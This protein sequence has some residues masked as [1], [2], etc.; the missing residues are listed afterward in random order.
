MH[1][2]TTDI[3][4]LKKRHQ[5]IDFFLNPGNQSVV[6]SLKSCLRSLHRLSPLIINK[7]SAPQAKYVDWK[8]FDQV[9]VDK[10]FSI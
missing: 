2:P 10:Y 4:L 5:V 8:K 7:I 9:L 6:D 3:E 1:H